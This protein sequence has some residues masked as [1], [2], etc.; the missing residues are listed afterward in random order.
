MACMAL[1]S[2]CLAP[3]LTMISPGSIDNP[4]ALPSHFAT[5]A[6]K[7][8]VPSTRVYFVA[9]ASSARLAASLMW[10]GVSKSG[11]PAPKLITSRPFARKAAALAETASVGDGSMSDNRR[12][13]F[14]ERLLLQVVTQTVFFSSRYLRDKEAATEGGTIRETSPP[15]SA[16]SFTREEDT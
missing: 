15:I 12:A 14:N 11:S 10:A 13:S 4:C 1:N 7:A 8:G 6:R 3:A 9:P 2:D 5:A 16:T